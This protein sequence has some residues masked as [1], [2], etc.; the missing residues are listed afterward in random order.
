MAKEKLAKGAVNAKTET[1]GQKKDTGP[2]LP[3]IP[4]TISAPDIPKGVQTT[5]IFFPYRY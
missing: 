1:M 2:A 3:N 5:G 4:S